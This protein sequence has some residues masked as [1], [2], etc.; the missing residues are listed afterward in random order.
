MQRRSWGLLWL[1]ISWAGCDGGDDKEAPDGA[2]SDAGF[3]AAWSD[4]GDASLDGGATLLDADLG[5]DAGDAGSDASAWPPVQPRS[6]RISV[7]GGPCFGDC[8]VFSLELDEAGQVSFWGGLCT[9]RPGA[10]TKQVASADARMLYAALAATQFWS[11]GDRYVNEQDGC[12]AVHADDLTSDWKIEVDGRAKTLTHDLGCEGLAALDQ[13]DAL[14]PL[15]R[16]LS[17]VDAW[18]APSPVNCGAGHQYKFSLDAAYRLSYGGQVLG[19]LTLDAQQA[20]WALHDCAGTR[21]QGGDIVLE[22]SRWILLASDE[23]P[24]YLPAG[25]GNVGS[26]LL[27]RPVED[28]IL[29]NVR[30][31]RAADE[32]TLS[33]VSASGC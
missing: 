21:L 4:A 24:I 28:V 8:P 13:I 23:A 31:L 12:P 19:V 33:V 3:D 7:A 5:D 9:A 30:A 17:G 16:Q 22:P 25:L 20:H 11:L 27:E 18:I 10:Y 1:A 6:F 29:P 14:V 2:M 32:L 15:A 26:I